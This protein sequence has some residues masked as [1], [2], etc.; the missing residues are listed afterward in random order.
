MKRPI[1][2]L[3]NR[4]ANSINTTTNLGCKKGHVVEYNK[5]CTATTHLN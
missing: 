3:E 5:H 2:G 1:K 4:I